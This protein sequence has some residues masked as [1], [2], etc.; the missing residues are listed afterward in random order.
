MAATTI[1]KKLQ[2]EHP[3]AKILRR[4]WARLNERNEHWMHCIVGR[5]GSGKSLTAIR[6]GNLIDA[7]FTAD[8]VY[9]RPAELLRQLR[10][11]EYQQGDVYVLDE[12]GVGLG[13]RTWQESGQKRLNQALQLIRNHNVGLIFTL[14]RLSELD[15]QAQG[16]LH[17]YHEIKSK[18]PDE[19]VAGPWHWMDPDRAD[20]TG[21]VY[22]KKPRVDGYRILSVRLQPPEDEELVAAYEDRKSEFQAEFY[23][24]AIDALTDGE[25]GEESDEPT[26]P[27]EIAQDI[28][29]NGGPEQFIREYNN[30]AQAVLDKEAI[31]VEYGVG[32]RKA[33]KVKTI[34][35]DEVD[36]EGVM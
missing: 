1:P 33:K 36:V 29:D 17:S 18:E 19:W 4:C 15:S 11:G 34:L 22:R 31:A 9:F 12:A 2:S 20:I 5:E 14:P 10:D 7:S 16:R 3:T 8:Q 24:E 13:R 26:S 6:L 21:E 27:Q 25:S 28:R 23:D 32:D 35:I 30:G